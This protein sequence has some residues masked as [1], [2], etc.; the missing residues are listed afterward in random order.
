[1]TASALDGIDDVD[2]ASLDHA[3]GSAQDVPRTLRD[4]VGADEGL[5]G[6][7]F[8]HLFGSIYHQGTLYSATPRAVP[9]VARLAADPATPRRWGLGHRLG[10]IADTDDAPPEVLA[11][12]RAA[13]SL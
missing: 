3:Y 8:E 6:E 1:M 4:A 5:A 9:F 13:L 12:V 11:D 10:A 2:W 7:A